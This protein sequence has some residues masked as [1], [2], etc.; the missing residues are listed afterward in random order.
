MST[1]NKVTTKRNRANSDV[2]C[3]L[4]F[5]PSG[6]RYSGVAPNRDSRG[7]I[8]SGASV[9]RRG[10]WS[11]TQRRDRPTCPWQRPYTT[12][13]RGRVSR[14]NPARPTHHSDSDSSLD[15]SVDVD[16]TVVDMRTSDIAFD[17]PVRY[18]GFNGT[19]KVGNRVSD[20]DVNP[21]ASM[22]AHRLV[23]SE[24]TYPNATESCY[25]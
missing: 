23:V 20:E 10:S 22:I 11:S 5:P 3:R 1:R 8:A 4:E 24:H 25:L 9:Q 14:H 7:V 2:A 15:L 21:E 13:P 12:P 18:D 17:M 16:A 6:A 19:R